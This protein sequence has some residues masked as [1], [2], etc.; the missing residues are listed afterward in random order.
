[1]KEWSKAGVKAKVREKRIV[2]SGFDD[3]TRILDAVLKIHIFL[4]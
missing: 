2:G 4:C 1:M 3:A